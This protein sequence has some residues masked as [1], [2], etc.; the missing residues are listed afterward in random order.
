MSYIRCTSNPEGLYIIDSCFGYIEISHSL[1]PPFCS[2]GEI[3]QIP[4]KEWYGLFALIN[5]YWHGRV[6]NIFKIKY[7]IFQIE[8][9]YISSV[10]GEDCA[11]I[12]SGDM[13]GWNKLEALKPITQFKVS[14]GNNF[15]YCYPVTLQYI[16]NNV[17]RDIL[18]R[19]KKK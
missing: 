16:A 8:E 17:I 14:Y 6:I 1:Q 2:Q 13:S 11:S 10:T 18:R 12:L 4:R 3:I 15:F 7:G 9:C 19:R 5:D